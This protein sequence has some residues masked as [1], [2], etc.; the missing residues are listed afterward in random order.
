MRIQYQPLTLFIYSTKIEQR[1]SVANKIVNFLTGA[2]KQKRG[3][4]PMA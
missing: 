2:K 4:I 3:Y 1:P